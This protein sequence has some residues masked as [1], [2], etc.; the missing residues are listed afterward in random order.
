MTYLELAVLL[1]DL[2]SLGGVQVLVNLA[3]ADLTVH[4]AALGPRSHIHLWTA[5]DVDHLVYHMCE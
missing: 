2:E 1:C 3:A 4:V 5:R